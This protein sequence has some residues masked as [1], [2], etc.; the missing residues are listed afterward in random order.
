[1]KNRDDRSLRHFVPETVRQQ[2]G[3]YHTAAKQQNQTCDNYCGTQRCNFAIKRGQLRHI[4]NQQY[5]Q[6]MYADLCVCMTDYKT[7]VRNSRSTP[8]GPLEAIKGA[9]ISAIQTPFITQTALT[10]L[11]TVLCVYHKEV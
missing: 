2:L 5:V 4:K 3:L 7:S 9:I 1:M 6:N 8:Q 11:L 10:T